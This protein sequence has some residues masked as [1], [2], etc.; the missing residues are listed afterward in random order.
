MKNMLRLGVMPSISL[1]VIKLVS[2]GYGTVVS[3][4]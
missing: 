3:A 4:L 2:R 1:F